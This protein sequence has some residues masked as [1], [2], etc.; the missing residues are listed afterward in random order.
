VTEYIVNP[1]RGPR[2][3]SRCAAL[4]HAPDSAWKAET[5]DIGPMGCQLVAPSM[6]GRGLPLTIVF[7]NPKL[8]GS[9]S[10]EGR[11]AWGSSRPPWRVGVAFAGSC[12]PQAE[13]WFAQLVAAFPGMGGFRRV[14]D[15]LPVDAMLFLSPPPTFLLDF[16]TEELEVLRHVAS[17]TTV[18]S[19]RGRLATSWSA[20][21]RA[22]FSLM[23]RGVVTLSR[24][25]AAHPSTW[26][27][28]MS[29]LEF[30]FVMEMP[31]TYTPLPFLESE[32]S[33][34]PPP[35][36]SGMAGDPGPDT[37]PA[38]T[39]AQLEDLGTLEEAP[40]AFHST[41]GT[42]W[43]GGVR[44]RSREAQESFDLGR[45]ELAAGRGNSALAHLRRALQLSPGDSEIAAEI[46][47]AIKGA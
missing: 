12:R 23:A 30:E 2:A 3:P 14:P 37:T 42:G 17:G 24:G 18:A 13:R 34:G 9:L 32:A 41:A 44:L 6:M 15:R 22:V 16:S 4:V 40:P 47:R 27:K 21:Q 1:R 46:G 28:V 45:T 19:L 7:T 38:I 5:E 10:A 31:P 8:P 36:E 25:A 29:D 20:S 33:R 35:S 26:K 11:V 39:V 43:R